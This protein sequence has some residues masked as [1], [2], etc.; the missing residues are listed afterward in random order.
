MWLLKQ[1]KIILGIGKAVL[2]MKNKNIRF[3]YGKA[4]KVCEDCCTLDVGSKRKC[5]V[6]GGKL[7]KIEGVMYYGY[8]VEM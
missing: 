1:L 2:N 6:C 3:P 4:V 8:K 5:R 7:I